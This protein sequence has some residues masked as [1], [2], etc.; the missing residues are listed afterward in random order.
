MPLASDYLLVDEAPPKA[1]ITLNRPE[2]LN[3][4]STGLMRELTGTLRR[5]AERED[6]RVIVIRGAGRA[7][8]AGHDLK[9]MKDRSLEEERAIFAVCSEMMQTIQSIPQPVIAAVHGIATAAGCQLVA[10]CDLAVCTDDSRFATSGIRYGLFCSTPGV[11]V[12]RNVGRKNALYMLLTG[13]FI[14]AATAERWGLVNR[15]VPANE[16]DAAVDDLVAELAAFSRLAL[17]M[18]KQGFYQQVEASQSDAYAMMSEAIAV[19]ACDPDGQ[20]G[21]NA[22]VEKRR[23]SWPVAKRESDK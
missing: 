14:D 21:I 15:A 3:P 10:T 8:S 9:E 18:G 6:I 20:E 13:R 22:F 16:L 5:L 11:A 17:G 19:N 7:F 2:Q 1:T 12:A 23:P 4:L